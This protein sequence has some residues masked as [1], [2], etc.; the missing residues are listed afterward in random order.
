[1]SACL[2]SL[3]LS[4]GVGRLIVDTILNGYPSPVV[5]VLY[6]EGMSDAAPVESFFQCQYKVVAKV[7]QVVV[8]DDLVH[9]LQRQGLSKCVNPSLLPPSPRLCTKNE[10]H[11]HNLVF[12][13]PQNQVAGGVSVLCLLQNP[14]VRGGCQ[15]GGENVHQGA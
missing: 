2:Y 15:G 8:F 12:G 6:H 13:T 1:M 10:K 3:F 4:T 11:W 5:L 7:G 9:D 14:N